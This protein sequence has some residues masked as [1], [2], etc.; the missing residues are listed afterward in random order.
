MQSQTL[1]ANA[2]A[3]AVDENALN[4]LLGRAI[5]DVGAT[6]LATLVLIGDELGLYRGLAAGGALVAA[7]GA[8]PVRGGRLVAVEAADGKA[9]GYALDEGGLLAHAVPSTVTRPR[10]FGSQCAQWHGPS[11]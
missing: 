11:V 10:D 9:G 2:P 7:A 5:N 6:S 1:K 8:E 4:E 3:P